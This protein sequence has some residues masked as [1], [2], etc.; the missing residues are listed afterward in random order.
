MAVHQDFPG[1]VY[2]TDLQ[3]PGM[4]VD[5]AVILVWVGVESYEVSSACWG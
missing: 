3:A 1:M 5:A 2:D 4:P